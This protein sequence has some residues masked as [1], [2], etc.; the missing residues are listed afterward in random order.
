L[1]TFHR[2]SQIEQTEGGSFLQYAERPDDRDTPFLGV[3]SPL[4]VVHN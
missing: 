1:E 3:F 4:S 2:H